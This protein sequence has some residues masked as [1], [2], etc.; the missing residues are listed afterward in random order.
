M[1]SELI[2]KIRSLVVLRTQVQPMF[3][4]MLL[5][6]S[7]AWGFTP[8]QAVRQSLD[9][10]PQLATAQGQLATA[11]A[12]RNQA[13]G[14]RY[15]PQLQVWAASPERADMDASLPLSLSGEGW[16]AR[17]A[18]GHQV[19][20]GTESLRR[21][22]L[23][24][25]A[26]VRRAYAQ[27]AVAVGLVGVALEGQ[28]LAARLRYGVGRKFQ[29]GEASDLE[30]RLA[31]LTET[32]AAVRLLE[33][34]QEEAMALRLL[35]SWVQLPLRASD[36]DTDPLSTVPVSSTPNEETRSDVLAAQSALQAAEAQ[37]RLARASALPP[38]SVGLGLELEGGQPAI[39]PS[40]GVRLPLASRNQVGRA[41]AQANVQV[42]EAQ[43]SGLEAQVE[44]E[45]QTAQLRVEQGEGLTSGSLGEPM[46]ELQDAHD[47]LASVEAGVLAGEIDLSSAVLLQSQILDGEAAVVRLRGLLADAALDR[48]LAMD[49]AALLGG[50]P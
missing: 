3:V 47:A 8:D 12:Q 30:L 33:A 46:G 15:N 13:R 6:A 18:A 34:R 49:D 24:V 14:L 7:L 22:Q 23:I 21:T 41:Q 5:S 38:V 44:V 50:A 45:R 35:V 39:G 19:R 40:L 28:E 27:A 11:Q 31:K 1:A 2:F 10:H 9:V 20:A 48:M 16:F 32:Q 29:E 36:L 37:L 26:E 17:Q 43:L 42:A 4:V 25:A